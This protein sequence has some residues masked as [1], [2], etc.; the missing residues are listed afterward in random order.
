MKEFILEDMERRAQERNAQEATQ[1]EQ[2]CPVHSESGYEQYFERINILLRDAESKAIARE[3]IGPLNPHIHTLDGPKWKV[4]IK[5]VVRKFI[6]WFIRPI[7]EQQSWYNVLTNAGSNDLRDSLCLLKELTEENCRLHTE[8]ESVRATYQSKIAEIDRRFAGMVDSQKKLRDACLNELGRTQA[9]LEDLRK[10]LSDA[11][12][13]VFD[14]IDYRAFEDEF[15]GSVKEI[16]TRIGRYLEY[17]KPGETVLDLGCGRGEWLELL[18]DKGIEA[19]GVDISESFVSMCRNKGLNVVME[20]MF[21]YLE[22]Q[23]DH[24]LDGITAI[25]VIEH[26]TPVALAKLVELC[27][28][29]LK[30]GGR[31]LFETQNPTSVSAM[32]GYFYVDPTHI[33]P[34]H[35]KWLE[36]L[37]QA[38]SFTEITVE[39]PNNPWVTSGAIPALPGNEVHIRLFNQRIEYLNNLLYGSTDYTVIARK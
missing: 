20:D 6:W 23:P 1:T 9:G 35:P 16:R 19:V 18:V 32:T 4:F 33:R 26:V 7:V 21:S 2:V 27:Y 5:R 37:L 39:Y 25:Q 8:L 22:H 14:Y 24:S 10:K 31:V 29:K 13:D 38:N 17:F 34:V 11:E 15:R 3:Q 30:L 12:E 28:R 36:Y